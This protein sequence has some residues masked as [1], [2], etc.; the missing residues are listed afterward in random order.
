MWLFADLQL[1]L[2]ACKSK[3]SRATGPLDNDVVDASSWTTTTFVLSNPPYNYSPFKIGL[4]GLLGI[5]GAILAPQWGRL[6]DRIVPWTGQVLGFTVSL[7]GMII[8]LGGADKTI[9]CVCIPMILYDVGM[10]LAQVATVY[11]IQGLEPDARSRM[12]GIFLL[13]MFVGQVSRKTLTLGKS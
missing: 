4:F 2:G 11:R 6:V 7:C 10:Q 5:L 9:A 8:A 12:N 1:F 13:L 3:Q